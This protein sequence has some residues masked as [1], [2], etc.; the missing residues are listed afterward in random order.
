MHYSGIAR[1]LAP[2]EQVTNGYQPGVARPLPSNLLEATWLFRESA[3]ARKTFGDEFVDHYSA[4][5]EWEWRQYE[6]SVTN[7]ELERY[8]EAI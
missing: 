4:T 1:R 7:W 3:F 2:P 5:R 6:K 8:F